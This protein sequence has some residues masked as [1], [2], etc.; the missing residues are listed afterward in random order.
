MS[1]VELP[2]ESEFG[3]DNLPYGVARH[4]DGRQGAVVAIGDHALALD[5][6]Q[7]AGLFADVAALP[8]DAFAGRALNGFLAL[9]PDVWRATR[10][11]LIDVLTDPRHRPATE[12]LLQP[13]RDLV[14][15]LP[16]QI[17]DYVDFYSSLHHATNLGRLFR[18]DGDPL[19]PNWRRIPVGYHGRAG[20][21]V[22]SGT[23]VVRPKGMIAPPEAEPRYAPTAAL[24]IELEVGAVIGAGSTL[25]QPIAADD[26]D[27]HVFGLVL[28][29]D[30]SARDIQAFEY[31]PLGPHLGKSFV[32]SMSPWIVTLDALRP[33]VVPGPPQDPPPDRY[34]QTTRP[35]AVDLELRVELSSATMRAE[36]TPAETIAAVNFRTMYWTLAQQLA[37]LTAN[38]ACVRPGDLYASGTVSGPEPGSEGS[39]IEL[40]WRGQRPLQ[41][42][43]GTTRAFLADGDEV[44]MRGWC[45]GESGSR[46]GFGHVAGVVEPAR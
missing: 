36:G 24:D 34:L 11:R 23:P 15:Q 19:L 26:A 31:Q 37:H 9:G 1:W 42:P 18:P 32:T 5:G 35:W 41:L 20:T 45:G 38:G 44:V 7:R 12:P 29:N 28:V 6:A 22:V 10:A 39:L 4:A 8:D 25:G 46:I 33:F 3:I 30:W 40:T 17:G 16:V 43:D 21:V 14:M 27:Q 2:A 13:R